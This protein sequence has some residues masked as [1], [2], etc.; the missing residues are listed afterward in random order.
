[1]GREAVL[2]HPPLPHFHFT[3]ACATTIIHT[4]ALPEDQEKLTV[5]EN[6]REE[7]VEVSGLL[8]CQF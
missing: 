5:H 7:L 8:S 2:F 1:L 6:V 3:V 4:L